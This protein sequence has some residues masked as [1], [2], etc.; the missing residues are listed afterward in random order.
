MPEMMPAVAVRP[1]TP[2][3]LHPTTLPRPEPGPGEVLVKVLR[4]GVCGTD[5]EIIEAKFGTAP[6][7]SEALVLGHEVFGVVE[8]A[9]P[10]AGSAMAPGT[11]V[12]TTVR[13]P[14]GCAPC[15]SG[16]GDFCADLAYTEHGI[17][18]LHGFMTEH[19]V[20]RPERLIAVP[21]AL[22]PV[23]IL[24]EPLSVVEKALQQ[25]TAIQRRIDSWQPRTALVLGAGPIG[26]L[27]TLL[28]RSRG[29]E[30]VTVARRHAPNAPSEIIEAAGGRY[31]SIRERALPEIAAELPPID[32]IFECSGNATL[33]FD[34]TRVLGNNGVLVLLSITGG[35]ATTPIPLDLINREFVLGNKVMVGSVNSSKIHFEMGVEDLARFEGLW[36]GLTGRM[37]TRRLPGLGAWQQITEREADGIK[38]VIEV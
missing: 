4:V 8:A 13:R 18:G 29:M 36:P 25:A 12:T 32:L 6:S 31:V 22:E 20:E 28:L 15:Q 37:I 26:L 11:Y 21:A 24:T 38:T 5:M 1:G 17:I 27:G 3:S 7:G 14:G 19:F 30:V 23:G 33:A 16:Q 2:H 35:E 9:G 10:G 34:A